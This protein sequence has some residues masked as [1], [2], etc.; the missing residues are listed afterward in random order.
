MRII[1]DLREDVQNT[2]IVNLMDKVYENT[3]YLYS[4]INENTI[5]ARGRIENLEEFKSKASEYENN[6]EDPTF[7][8]FLDNISLVSDVDNYD[9]E[10]DAIVLMTLHSAKGLEFPVVF[11]CGLEQ[12]LFPSFQSME[13]DEKIE[14]ERRLCY[15]GITRAR[16]KLYITYSMRRIMYGK[17]E[18]KMV[19]EFVSEIPDELIDRINNVPSRNMIDSYGG[20]NTYGR[21]DYSDEGYYKNDSIVK[22]VSSDYSSVISANTFMA[23]SA[24]KV[25]DTYTKGERVSHKK[26][27]EGMIVGV[28]PIGDDYQL[29]IS[30]D[31]VG[32]RT[33]MASF[34]KL[35]KL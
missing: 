12:G 30:F 1:E 10:Q 8:G 23:S 29:E 34:A 14:E 21:N 32:T 35:K 3:G 5:E 16:N 22:G 19:S 7:A 18:S 20:Y 27:G 9:D 13:E 31:N 33:L 6:V 2:S 15:V 24:P 26:F 25:S 11:M 4:L 28:N 17:T